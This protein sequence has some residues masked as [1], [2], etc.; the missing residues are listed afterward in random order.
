MNM[1]RKVRREDIV[2]Y[3]TW[4]DRR[5]SERERIMAIKEPRRVHVGENLTF[6]F[7]N[8]DTVRYQI[9]EM[10]RT[11]QIVKED[12]IQH[13]IETYNELLGGAGDIGCVLLIEVETPQERA[14]KLV[15]WL[16]L[17]KHLYVELP[18]GTKVR[19]TYDERQVGEQRVSSV[20]YLVFETGGR[21]PV[22]VGSDLPALNVRAELNA[23]Q[24][25]A[26]EEDLRG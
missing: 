8:T 2:D 1:A 26:I 15:Q 24:R 23:A 17:P 4:S 16:D 6:L 7:E 3:Q 20:Q 11:E 14:V 21:V 25:K 10:M 5:E 13:E 18:D 9:Q 22:A 12:A 19:P